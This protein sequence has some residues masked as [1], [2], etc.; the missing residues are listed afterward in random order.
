MKKNTF[1]LPLPARAALAVLISFM[2]VLPVLGQSQ[3]EKPQ[4]DQQQQTIKIGTNLVTVPVIVTDRY[5]RFVPGLTRNEFSVREE[6]SP[7]RIEDFSSTEAPFSVALLID[8][9]RS[10]Q[11]KLSRIRKAAR[12]FI[13]QLLPNDRIM[14]VSFDEQVRFVCDFTSDHAELERAV[15]SLET[16]YQ[17]KLYDAIHLTINEKMSRIQGRKA[18]VVLTDG[19]DTASKQATYESAID[20]AASAGIIT[21]TIQYETRNDGGPLMKPRFIPGIS[22]S[23]APSSGLKWQDAPQKWQDAPQQKPKS[24]SEASKSESK[25]ESKSLINIPR[26]GGGASVATPGSMPSSRVNSQRQQPIRD[27]YL[28][29]ADFLSTLAGQSGGLPF[30]AESI[31]NTSYAFQ[32]IANELHNQYT[33]TYISSNEQ[34]DGNYRAI[35]VGVKNSAL[36]V[37]ARRFY[38]SPRGETPEGDQNKKLD[39]KPE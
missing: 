8:T 3:E 38:R 7:Q 36:V 33:L 9:S 13:K 10:T 21:Y 23:F 14:V 1:P 39:P 19:V 37:R 12:T 26:P 22:N 35:A 15:K 29:A 34:R 16:S 2:A 17:T 24:E 4:Q 32:L 25:D 6:G 28:I 5:G 31:E 11:N 27:R 30:R 18:I 20:L